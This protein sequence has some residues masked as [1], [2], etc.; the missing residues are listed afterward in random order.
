MWRHLRDPRSAALL[1]CGTGDRRPSLDGS[2]ELPVVPVDDGSL[3]C[4]R[5]DARD[6]NLRRLLD[7]EVESVLLRQGLEESDR[8]TGCFDHVFLR[9]RRDHIVLDRGDS[10]A[11]HPSRSVRD[12]D[13]FTEAHAQDARSV[14][15]L[16]AF[17]RDETVADR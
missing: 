7:D 10:R 6:A 2:A 14:T 8:R 4:E 1:R 9:D 16:V 3:R 17:D 13:V 11:D 15:S 12:G 5:N